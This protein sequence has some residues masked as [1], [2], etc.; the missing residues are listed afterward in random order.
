MLKN[1]GGKRDFQ[2][3][4]ERNAF[5][6]WGTIVNTE[7]VNKVSLTCPEK[8]EHGCFGQVE[9]FSASCSCCQADRAER[10]VLIKSIQEQQNEKA[11]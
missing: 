2:N 3:K 7:A 5:C 4:N 9:G 6:G 10:N 8:C 11:I 1:K